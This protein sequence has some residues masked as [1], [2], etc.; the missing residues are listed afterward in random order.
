[1]LRL[2]TAAIALYESMRNAR[3]PRTTVYQSPLWSSRQNAYFQGN[4]KIWRHNGKG[5][6]HNGKGRKWRFLAFFGTKLDINCTANCL[7]QRD[8]MRMVTWF[9]YQPRTSLYFVTKII[10]VVWI[11]FLIILKSNYHPDSPDVIQQRI[12]M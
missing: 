10:K 6:R 1:M 7:S 2:L 12:G 4:C 8:F 5:W 3:F 9:L 11:V